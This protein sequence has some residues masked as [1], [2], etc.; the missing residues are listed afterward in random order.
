LSHNLTN[1]HLHSFCFA[2]VARYCFANVCSVKLFID[3]YLNLWV[4]LIVIILNRYSVQN[5]LIAATISSFFASVLFC[6]YILCI[7]T[8]SVLLK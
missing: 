3:K 1:T 7:G 2:Q 6:T 8:F 5:R 4:A